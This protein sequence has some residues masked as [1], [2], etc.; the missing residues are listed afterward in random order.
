MQL[1]KL[2]ARGEAAIAEC[3][4]TTVHRQSVPVCQDLV[5]NWT[6]AA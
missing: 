3:S 5:T 2:I 6:A 4:E 1:A